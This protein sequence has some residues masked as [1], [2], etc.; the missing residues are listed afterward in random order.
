MTGT[1]RQKMNMAKAI[2]EA[3]YSK[4]PPGRFLKKCTETGQWKE[5]SKM[6]AANKAVQAMGYA[7]RGGSCK[8]K[9]RVRRRRSRSLPSW[10][11][12]PLPSSKSRNY[13]DDVGTASS[14]ISDRLTNNH[15]EGNVVV[16]SSVA[17]HELVASRGP[18]ATAGTT[19]AKSTAT[20]NNGLS[21]SAA[22][23][24]ANELLP[25]PTGNAHLQQEEPLQQLQQSSRTILPISLVAPPTAVNQYGLTQV[26]AHAHEQQQRHHHQQQQQQQHLLQHTL[27]Q[28][29][30]LEGLHL[31]ALQQLP[32]ALLEG[33]A[34]LLAQ[35][36]QQQQQLS[37]LQHAFGQHTSGLPN[38]LYPP[39][40]SSAPSSALPTSGI[41]LLSTGSQPQQPV[42]SMFLQNPVQPQSQHPSNSYLL[43]M[44]SHLQNQPNT[45]TGTSNAPQQAHQM[46]DQVQRT[47]AQQQQQ[48]LVLSLISSNQ[49]L[50]QQL[51]RQTPLH[52]TRQ[53]TAPLRRDQNSQ[54]SQPINAQ[55][56][57]NDNAA[58]ASCMQEESEDE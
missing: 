30:P 26:L 45:G 42:N 34:Q 4:E 55:P 18:A 22:N 14:Q 56:S 8:Q 50:L 13:Y 25:I 2:V 33:L 15:L 23:E 52:Q 19:H 20:V 9:K 24:L 38:S 47:L 58:A 10:T 37:L 39:T 29:L 28:N 57:A 49:L 35:K 36:D 6:E 51:Q 44:L 32:T 21:D 11:P 43:S 3:I 1:K 46:D 17:H 40:L 54:S 48:L 12:P 7:V 5:L 31:Q 53:T 41:L 16:A 27:G